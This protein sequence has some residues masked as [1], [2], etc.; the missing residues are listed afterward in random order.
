MLP[1]IV[2]EDGEY[3][4]DTLEVL[5]NGETYLNQAVTL[6]GGKANVSVTL[7]DSESAV[8]KISLSD[9]GAVETKNINADNSE[10]ISVDFTG[11]SSDDSQHSSTPQES[12]QSA[13]ASAFENTT[14]NRTDATGETQNVQ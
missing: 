9:T 2:D 10:N 4:T 6:K 5:L 8:I 1:E 11:F 13:T 12:T 3:T 14:G 7:E